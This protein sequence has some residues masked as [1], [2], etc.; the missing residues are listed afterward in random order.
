[1]N[2]EI[3]ILSMNACR[4]IKAPTE[5]QILNT[6]QAMRICCVSLLSIRVYVLIFDLCT[7]LDFVVVLLEEG[8][9]LAILIPA[10]LCVSGNLC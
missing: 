10:H 5:K 7:N 9:F 3:I 6:N 2:N 8:G 4:D 1:M